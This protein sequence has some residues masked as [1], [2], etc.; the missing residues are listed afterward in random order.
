MAHAY[1][2][3]GSAWRGGGVWSGYE[4]VTPLR[5]GRVAKPKAPSQP[6]WIDAKGKVNPKLAPR[7]L[8]LVGSNG[9]ILMGTMGKA[10]MVPSNIAPPPPVRK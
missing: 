3:D 10:R 2:W 7:E 5:F 1:A 4:Y 8:P 6:K 9:K